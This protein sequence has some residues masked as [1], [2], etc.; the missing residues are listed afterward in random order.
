M[1]KQTAVNWLQ[2]LF[3]EQDYLTEQDFEQAKKIEKQQMDKIAGDFWNEGASYMRDGFRKYES[4]E[5]YYEQT[6]NK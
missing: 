4:F 5:D 1:S 3:E 2:D 6:F